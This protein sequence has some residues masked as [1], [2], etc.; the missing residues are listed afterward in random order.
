MIYLKLHMTWLHFID[1]YSSVNHFC[2]CDVQ[3]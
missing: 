3:I 2:V 1:T